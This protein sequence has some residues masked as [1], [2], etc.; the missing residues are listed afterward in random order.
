MLEK[1]LFMEESILPCDG[2]NHWSILL[3]LNLKYSL[4]NF[5]FFF[6]IFWII[7]PSFVD[8]AKKWWQEIEA[9][10]PSTIYNF[11]QNLKG[12]KAHIKNNG[13]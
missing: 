11:Q 4:K 13:T 2:S 6:D 3:E 8:K 10:S 9:P 5:Q 7:Y 1:D 12:L